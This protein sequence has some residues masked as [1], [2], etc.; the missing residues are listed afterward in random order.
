MYM[1]VILL[2]ENNLAVNNSNG[3]NTKFLT[4]KNS[5]TQRSVSWD[6]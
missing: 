1:D 5:T 2:S 3:G 6:F 4:M